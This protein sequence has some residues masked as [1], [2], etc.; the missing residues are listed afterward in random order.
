ML[1]HFICILFLFGLRAPSFASE[2][3]PSLIKNYYFNLGSHTEFYDAVQNDASG[4]LRKFE[5]APTI[6]FGLAM[7]IS[8]KLIFL[9]EFNWVLPKTIEDSH[10][11]IN[12]FMLRGDLGFDPLDWLRLRIGTSL[13][14]QNQ[15][16]RAGK[17]QMNNGDSTST[18]YYPD[19]NRSSLNNTFDVGAETIFDQFAIRLQTYTYSLF[20]KEQRQF[21]YTLFFSYYWGP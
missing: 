20:K 13:M 17:V 6:G 7:P 5:M 8:E 16:G 1:R 21:S 4:G 15:Q 2:G 19:E 10:I 11:M 3:S 18:F 14:W 12:T 9:P